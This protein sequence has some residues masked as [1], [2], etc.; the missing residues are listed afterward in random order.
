MLNGEPF[1]SLFDLRGYFNYYCRGPLANVTSK[2]LL[3]ICL[4]NHKKVF[5]PIYHKN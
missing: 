1:G 2:T 4:A 3:S 5:F